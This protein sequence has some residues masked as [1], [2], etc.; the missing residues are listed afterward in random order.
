[1]KGLFSVATSSSKSASFIRQEL[2]RCFKLD[3]IEFKEHDGFQCFKKGD[4]TFLEDKLSKLKSDGKEDK[5]ESV[6]KRDHFKKDEFQ[7]DISFEVYIVKIGWIG[8]RGVR[9]RRIY[10]D[11]W[12]YKKL[13]E[14]LLA[15]LSL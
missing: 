3:E 1:M 9:F 7:G 4:L 15:E 2:I 13:I 11:S 5:R 10:G 6:T 12:R 8:L 14:K